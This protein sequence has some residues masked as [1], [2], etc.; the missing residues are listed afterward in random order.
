MDEQVEKVLRILS[1]V[2]YTEVLAD[3]F[4]QEQMGTYR[5]AIKLADRKRSSIE[6]G[7]VSDR[8]GSVTSNLHQRPKYT[9]YEPVLVSSLEEKRNP[10]LSARNPRDLRWST[11]SDKE[12]SVS[13]SPPKAVAAKSV[14]QRN[15]LGAQHKG[16][17]PARQSGS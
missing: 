17:A 15:S 1:K 16:N 2:V 10:L 7:H 3:F 11:R 4:M 6:T 9:L 12:K 8:V 14:A 5:R 13:P